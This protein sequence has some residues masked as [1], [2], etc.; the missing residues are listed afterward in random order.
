MTVDTPAYN[1]LLPM[2]EGDWLVAVGEALDWLGWSWIHHRPGRTG[3]GWVTATQGNAAAGEPDILAIRVPRVLWLE[4]KTDKG[5]VSPEQEDWL[6]RLKDSGQEAHLIRLPREWDRLMELI[7]RDPDQL[8]LPQPD[9]VT[10]GHM[11][12]TA[13][14]V[15]WGR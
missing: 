11:P 8:T 15:R 13:A 2:L 14:P 6:A 5:R 9:D 12:I 4:L 1:P 3:S 7:A 10:D